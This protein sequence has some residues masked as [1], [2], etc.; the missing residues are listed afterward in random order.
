MLQVN[1]PRPLLKFEEDIHQYQD[2]IA[3]IEKT[4]VLPKFILFLPKCRLYTI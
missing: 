3:Q 2:T 4:E 1:P